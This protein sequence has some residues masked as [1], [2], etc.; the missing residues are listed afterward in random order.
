MTAMA[1]FILSA[2][3]KEG[4]KMQDTINLEDFFQSKEYK[5]LAK[6]NIYATLELLL[7]KGI[8]FS[9]ISYTKVI[10][11]NPPIPKE[12][13]EFDEIA[14]FIIAGYSYESSSLDKNSFSFEAGFGTENYGSV[15]TMPLEA[16]VQISIGEELL[17]INHYEPKEQVVRQE[18]SS[19]DILLNN[20]ENLKLIKRKKKK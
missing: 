6:K 14:M 20:P 3:K 2:I 10:D 15:L 4:N 9:I 5:E 8:E 16:I 12:I 18:T 13:I 17:L 19:M 1:S 7:K 11:F